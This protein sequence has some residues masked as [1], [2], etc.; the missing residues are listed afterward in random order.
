MGRRSTLTN[1]DIRNV[2]R[3]IGDMRDI[4]GDA[5]R[6][7]LIQGLCELMGARQGSVLHFQGFT[8]TGNPRL[9][10]FVGGG[11]ASPEAARLWEA[12]MATGNWR[13]DPVLNQATQVT[14]PS[15]A[16]RRCELVNDKDYY[17]SESYN[18]IAKA[19]G[20]DDTL[21]AWFQENT[22]GSVTAMAFQRGW[23]ES[24]FSP[25]Q[26]EMMALVVDEMRVLYEA[27]KLNKNSPIP[28]NLPPRLSRLL[29][30]LLTGKGEKQIATALGLSRFTVNDYAK[31]LYRYIG[32]ESRAELMAK[33]IPQNPAAPGPK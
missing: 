26:R 31:D 16:F 3:L 27:G 14:T 32:V 19:A 18:L 30:E 23:G 29:G 33:F 20:V 6:T 8:P 10:G 2:M 7:Q 25:R 5:G 22:P 17:S 9:D 28:Q 15:N 1:A 4:K 12:T 13:G 24:Q 21:V 11:W